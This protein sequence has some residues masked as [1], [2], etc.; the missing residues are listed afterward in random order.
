MDAPIDVIVERESANDTTAVVVEVRCASGARVGHEQVLFEIETSKTVQEVLAPAAGFVVHALRPGDTIRLADPIAQ[1]ASSEQALAE[2]RAHQTPVDAGAAGTARL[3][4]AA[5]ALARKNGLSPS[6]FSGDFVTTT[7]VRQR[8]GHAPPPTGTSGTAPSQPSPNSRPVPAHKREEIARLSHGPGATMLSVLGTP[9][10]AEPV[11]RA[12]AGFFATKISDLVV[13]EASRLM[14]KY[15]K[16]NAAYRDGA[17]HYYEDIHAGFA[18]D[19]GSKL[20]VYAVTD[21]HERTLPDIRLELLRG[22]KKYAKGTLTARDLDSATFTITDMSAS[23]IDFVL[24]L[25]QE[26]QSCILAITH[27]ATSGYHLYIGFDHRVTEGLEASRFL[28]ELRLRIVAAF[29]PYRD[30]T[31]S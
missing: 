14:P 12:D 19:E 31:P 25:L 5:L 10:G 15:P 21:S 30:A 3:S 20:V 29:A 2:L 16:L 1:I 4:R 6:D 7:D 27:T 28:K 9:L 24:P 18:V 17:I 23:E 26:G 13:Y 11:V 22:L 8:L